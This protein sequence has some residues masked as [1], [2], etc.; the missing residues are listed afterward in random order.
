MHAIEKRCHALCM[1][2]YY[3][4]MLRCSDGSYYTGVTNNVELRLAQHER[5]DDASCYTF[6]RRPMTLVYTCA[7]RDIFDAIAYEKK[8][9]RWSR[10]KKEALINGEY[11]NLPRLAES[12]YAK[13]IRVTR[14]MVRRAHHDTLGVV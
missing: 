3:V 7:F 14:L 13:R 8:L 10:R 9:K 1:R 12:M 4:Y 2:E 11:G 6:K 5:G